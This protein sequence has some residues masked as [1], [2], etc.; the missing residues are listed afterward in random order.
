MSELNRRNFMRSLMT[1]GGALALSLLGGTEASAAGP[2]KQPQRQWRRYEL[3]PE[4]EWMTAEVKWYDRIR[5]QGFLMTCSLFAPGELTPDIYVR[6][7]VV[8]KSA[9]P[10]LRVGQVVQVRYM[11]EKLGLCAIELRPHRA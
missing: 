9:M 5:G 8:E 2:S 7:D 10:P 6:G 1:G 11:K 3:K 4:G